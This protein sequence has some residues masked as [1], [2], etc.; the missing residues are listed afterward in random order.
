M[1]E[2]R[3]NYT[4]PCTCGDSLDSVK[5]QTVYRIVTWYCPTCG[6]TL[7]STMFSDSPVTRYYVNKALLVRANA[8]LREEKGLPPK[9]TIVTFYDDKGNRIL[10]KD[11]VAKNARW[12][13]RMGFVQRKAF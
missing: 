13:K 11:I 3:V 1:A 5:V 10:W 2:S 8:K 9:K 12:E 7:A 6:K 4:E